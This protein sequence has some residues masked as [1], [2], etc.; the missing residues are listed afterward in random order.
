MS[1]ILSTRLSVSLAA[2]AVAVT[3]LAAPA[4]AVD[5]TPAQNAML[6]QASDLPSSYGTPTDQSFTN[7]QKGAEFAVACFTATGDAPGTTVGDTLNL[8]SEI[9]Y[10][11][12]LNWIQDIYVYASKAKAVKAFTQMTNKAVP[13]CQ[14]SNTTTKGDDDVPMPA[15]TTTVSAKVANRVIVATLK[16]T[17]KPG[18]KPLYADSYSRRLTARVGTGI[19]ALQLNSTKPITAAQKRTQDSAFAKLLARY[20]G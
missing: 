7:V 12:G 6:L 10:A 1:R 9:D 14:G 18:A 2:A 19:E 13:Q 17:S 15:R 3:A 5:P 20:D 16:A 4:L 8:F 11:S